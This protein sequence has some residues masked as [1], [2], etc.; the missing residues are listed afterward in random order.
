MIADP[1][2]LGLAGFSSVVLMVSMYYATIISSIDWVS[3]LGNIAGICLLFGSAYHFAAGN[4]IP[5]TTF[6]VYGAFW[7]SVSIMII[8]GIVPLDSFNETMTYLRIP[9]AIFTLYAWIVS[10]F[11]SKV[12][13]CV[14]TTLECK[15]VC[16]IV[17]HFSK[18]QTLY[19]IGGSFGIVC[20]LLGFYT[21]AT[22]LLRPYMHLPLGKPLLSPFGGQV[23]QI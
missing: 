17:A 12:S 9:I 1:T 3:A 15:L 21:S 19:I 7:L 8:S 5:A 11:I 22:L 2:P 20:A 10:L 14:F 23:H 6:G 18:S 4:T 13:F 16:F